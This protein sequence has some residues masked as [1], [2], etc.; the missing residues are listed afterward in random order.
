[1]SEVV[2]SDVAAQMSGLACSFLSGNYHYQI[3]ISSV[4]FKYE[5]NMQHAIRHCFV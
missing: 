4:C 2:F 1:M 5:S 3:K